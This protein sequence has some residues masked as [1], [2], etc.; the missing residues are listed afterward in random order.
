MPNFIEQRGDIKGKIRLEIIDAATSNNFGWAVASGFL[1]MIPN[2]FGMPWNSYHARLEFEVTIFNS[3]NEPI[4]NKAYAGRSRTIYEGI[5]YA[6][7]A[8]EG[9]A[10]LLTEIFKEKLEELKKD[11]QAEVF[12]INNLLNER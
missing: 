8:G 12:E 5:Y 4:W 7:S 3:Y 6:Y 2:L 1:G 10:I 11:F 9:E